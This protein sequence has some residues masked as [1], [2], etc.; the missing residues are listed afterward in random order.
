MKREAEASLPSIA[1]GDG[2]DSNS[3]SR[4]IPSGASTGLVSC[5]FSLYRS[6]PTDCGG[7]SRYILSNPYRHRDRST[8]TFRRP[9]LTR[10]GEV[11][12]DVAAV[13]RLPVRIRVRQLLFCHLIYEGD[14]TSACN[15]RIKPPCRT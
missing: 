6:P 2:G 10:R 9:V 3:P 14:G 12:V 15:S 5:Y 13:F 1:G 4:R 7:A 11:E 8:S